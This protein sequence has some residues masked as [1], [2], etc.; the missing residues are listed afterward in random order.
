MNGYTLTLSRKNAIN[1]IEVDS[2]ITANMTSE[3][4]DEYTS[5][6]L[7]NAFSMEF[8]GE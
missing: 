5:Q 2:S 4:R 7:L 3:E 1:P 8:D 6:A